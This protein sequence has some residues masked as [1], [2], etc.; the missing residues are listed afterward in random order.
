MNAMNE[1]REVSESFD[2]SKV[3][4]VM[5]DDVDDVISN[6]LYTGVPCSWVVY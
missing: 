5:R 2:R 1:R 3:M 4:G 6:L